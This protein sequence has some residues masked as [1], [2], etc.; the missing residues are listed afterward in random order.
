MF[1]FRKILGPTLPCFLLALIGSA[2][3]ERPLEDYPQAAQAEYARACK[4]HEQGLYGPALRAYQEAAHLGLDDFRLLQVLQRECSRQY[5]ELL[6]TRYTQQ[7]NEAQL[8]R[9]SRQSLRQGYAGRS[10]ALGS[11]GRR[12][13]AVADQNALVALWESEVEATAGHDGQNRQALLQEAAKVHRDR[14]R[15]LQ[16]DSKNQE[17]AADFRRAEELEKQAN[18]V[19]PPTAVPERQGEKSGEANVRDSTMDPSRGQFP[20][21]KAEKRQ[22]KTTD[23]P[24]LPPVPMQKAGLVTVVNTYREPVV[25]KVNGRAFNVPVGASV[26]IELEPVRQRFTYELITPPWGSKGVQERNLEPGEKYIITVFNTN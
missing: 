22:E 10:A 4:L 1:H 2:R 6:V 17:A 24:K 26:S 16:D 9:G 23:L 12:G 8:G 18:E 7:I 20:P 19:A 3:A 11:L 15:F 13:E 21:T 14:G 5:Q 25:V